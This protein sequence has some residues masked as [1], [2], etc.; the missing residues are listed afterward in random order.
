MTEIANALLSPD[1]KPVSE[2]MWECFWDRLR[3]GGLVPGEAAAVLASLS[4]SIPEDRTLHA[5]LGS[6]R[7]RRRFP[8][9]RPVSGDAVNIVGTG[10]GPTTFNISTAAAM[11]AAAMGVRVIKTG[12]RAYSGLCG[13]ID[14]LHHLGLPLSES[15]DET[16]AMLDR[17]GIAF[18]GA[19]VYPIELRLL[20]RSILPLPMKVL[21]QFFN[22]IG[23]FLADVP[24]A[25]QLT[26]VSDTKLLP[27]FQGLAERFPDRRVWLCANWI[28]A[29]ELI[30]FTGNRLLGTGL[31][32]CAGEGYHMS[33]IGCGSLEDLRP[34][35]TTQATTAH[36]EAILAG[37]G[38]RAAVDTVCLNAAALALLA[39]LWDTWDE[40]LRA[41]NTTLGRGDAV[42][43]VHALRRSAGERT[44][45]NPARIPALAEPLPVGIR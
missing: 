3:D 10:G 4:T 27:R 35:A 30:S 42:R 5:L 32:K 17:F 45:S 2:E 34:A 37:E 20:S 13:S 18:A 39:G 22:T 12:S 7:R 23:P 8:A 28:G 21:G 25:G 29:D 40:A 38:P 11:V 43:L 9:E 14:L 19:Y 24:V 33:A 1:R 15:H 6:L 26:G 31:P 44:F 36:F 41:A 16:A